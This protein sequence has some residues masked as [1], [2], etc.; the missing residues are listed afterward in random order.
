M[1]NPTHTASQLPLARKQGFAVLLLSSL[2]IVS[3]FGF[4]FILPQAKA[5]TGGTVIDL[6]VIAQPSFGGSNYDVFFPQSLAVQQGNQVNLTVR[7]VGN[8]TF[9]L[10]IEGQPAVLVQAGIQNVSTVAPVDTAVLF[11]VSAVGIFSFAAAEHPEMNGQLIVLPSDWASYNPA[12]QTRSFTQL[13][14]PDFAGEGYDKYFPSSLVVNQGDTVNITFRN[15][16]DMAHGFALAIY[17]LTATLNSGKA[18]DNGSIIPVDTNIQ[19]FTATT[20]GV[21]SF[22]CTIPCGPGHLEMVGSLV[23]LPTKNGNGYNPVPVTQNSYLTIK[24]DVAGEEYD[25]YVP[26][27]VFVNQNDIVHINVRNTDT[28]VHGF[29]LPNY[30]INDVTITPATE[31]ATI[32]VVPTDTVIPDF[33][34]AQP[35]VFEFF[36][37][38]NCGA[39]HD[40]MTG[41]LVVL[42][43]LIASGGTPTTTAPSQ[44]IS[45]VIFICLII[46]LLVVCILIGIV[47]AKPFGNEEN[48]AKSSS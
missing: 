23:V 18:Q 15:T 37:S 3:A 8:Q 30:N 19:P 25:K 33:N 21:F 22:H 28:A 44:F 36:C 32:G 35:G 4:A 45:T 2:L 46:A 38:N 11:T 14:I 40:Q 16:D 17:G 42:P 24:P 29:S 43:A 39:G 26:D 27:A 12:S 10:Q 9:H 48:S 20:P 6:F 1:K 34:A 7:N 5:Q 13:I 41:Y 47:V 31:N